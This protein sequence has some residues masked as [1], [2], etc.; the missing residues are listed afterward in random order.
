MRAIGASEKMPSVSAGRTS[1]FKRRHEGFALAGD[2]AVDQVEAGDVRRRAEEH[3][4]PPK[5]RRRP[6][7]LVVE[8]V[9]QDQAGEEHRQRYAGRR[10]YPAGV[11][12]DRVRPCRRHDAERHRDQHRDDQAKQRQLGRRR[13]PRLDLV[14]HG[15]AGGE[16]VAEVAVR[17]IGDVLHE[18]DVERLV[19]PELHA[20]LL[21][22]F[23][24]GGGAGEVGGRVARQRTRQQERD[25]HH[26]DQAR[27][28]H[29]QSLEDHHQHGRRPLIH[30]AAAVSVR[31]PPPL[32]GWGR[33]VCVE[34]SALPTTTPVPALPHKGE[35]AD[36]VRGGIS[37]WP[38][39]GS[40][41]GDGTSTDS[42]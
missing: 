30:N 25:D 3:V 34:R 28:G 26:A 23:L 35:G 19:E 12:D 17:E 36:R 39:R 24:G 32:G 1:C 16:R 41:A 18:L 21:D 38:A 40:R 6:A 33:G 42:R 4:E 37:P 10:D 13:K 20:D 5:R 14:A 2:Q 29:Q 31:S 22:G 7:E 15:L 27:H 9:D 8:H 11:I